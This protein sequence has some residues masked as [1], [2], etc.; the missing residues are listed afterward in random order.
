MVLA[1]DCFFLCL[2]FRS[3]VPHRSAAGHSLVTLVLLL[4]APHVL[5]YHRSKPYMYRRER[6]KMQRQMHLAVTHGT[7]IMKRLLQIQREDVHRRVKHEQKLLCNAFRD[8]LKQRWDDFCVQGVWPSHAFGEDNDASFVHGVGHRTSAIAALGAGNFDG[9]SGDGDDDGSIAEASDLAIT[10]ETVEPFVEAGFPREGALLSVIVFFD[11][12]GVHGVARTVDV[13]G[14]GVESGE[15]HGNARGTRDVFE[16]GANDCLSAMEGYVVTPDQARADYTAAGIA[17]LRFHTLRGRQSP[18]FGVRPPA[19][20]GTFFYF[21]ATAETAKYDNAAAAA[22]AATHEAA[23]APQ[24]EGAGSGSESVTDDD[25]SARPGTGASHALGHVSSGGSGLDAAER[26]SRP[27]NRKLSAAQ[28]A[29]APR[30]IGFCGRKSENKLATLGIL[31]QR[32]LA[33]NVFG[34]CWVNTK[35]VS[36]QARA[37]HDLK[38][39]NDFAIVLRMRGSYVLDLLKRSQCL[40]KK[41]RATKTRAPLPIGEVRIAFQF[42]RWYFEA[43]TFGLVRVPTPEEEATANEFTTRGMGLLAQGNRKVQAAEAIFRELAEYVI[44]PPYVSCRVHLRF[45]SLLPFEV[46]HFSDKLCACSSVGFLPRQE[47]LLWIPQC[48]GRTKCWS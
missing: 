45:H 48:W 19:R 25:E 30:I 2:T 4:A 15:V 20:P 1:A 10:T 38:A 32:K 46:V 17:R 16:I 41:M 11:E 29:L 36:E 12:N 31:V 42:S 22:E 39:E 34:N 35:A 23:N 47:K 37:Q 18:W 40:A 33:P 21:D 5:R 13:P 8:R 24:D 14:I 9:G 43:L 6:A 7:P 26:A 28:V 44:S 3:I 27:A